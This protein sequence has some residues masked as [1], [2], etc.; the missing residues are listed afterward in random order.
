MIIVSHEQNFYVIN[1]CIFSIILGQPYIIAR[2][3]ETKV[4]DNG[5]TYAQIKS[6]DEKNPVQFFTIS[7]TDVRNQYTL[8]K[9][10]LSEIAYKIAYKAFNA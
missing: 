4:M 9:N 10:H 3:M 5:S 8:L 6:P 1:K 7:C 2:R